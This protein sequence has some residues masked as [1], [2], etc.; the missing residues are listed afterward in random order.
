MIPL[1]KR[2]RYVALDSDN[3]APAR[4]GGEGING[5]SGGGFALVVDSLQ[6]GGVVERLP[7]EWLSALSEVV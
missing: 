2:L 1:N 7:P 3:A 4:V 5:R 6:G